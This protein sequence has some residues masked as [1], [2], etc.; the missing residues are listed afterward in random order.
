MLYYIYNGTF[1]ENDELRHHGIK[2]MKWGVR[3]Q[4]RIAARDQYRKRTNAAF[5]EYE[6]T[7]ADIEKPYKKGQSLSKEDMYREQA[8]ERKYANEAARAKTDYKNAKS[9]IRKE[10]KNKYQKES[11]N[12]YQKE[13]DRQKKHLATKRATDLG[14]RA[15]NEYTKRHNV[16]LNSMHV[17]V[18]DSAKAIVNKLLDY[19]YMKDTFK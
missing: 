16:T 7:I 13:R 1:Y 6:R 2:G 15:V 4:R 10:S 3:R 11:K 14:I 5:E 18:S 19:K 9:S 8:A 17:G 12:E